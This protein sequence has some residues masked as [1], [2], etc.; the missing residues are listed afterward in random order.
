MEIMKRVLLIILVII[1]FL[2][3]IMVP[4]SLLYNYKINRLQK[5][6]REEVNERNVQT[7]TAWFIFGPLFKSESIWNR[8]IET[9]DIID[10][11]PDIRDETK[12]KLYNAYKNRG[13]NPGKL[14]N[15]KYIKKSNRKNK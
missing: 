7:F 2:P 14:K 13:C 6:I 10:D 4:I 5:K 9:F 11:N 15:K 3:F 12:E 1:F 8:L